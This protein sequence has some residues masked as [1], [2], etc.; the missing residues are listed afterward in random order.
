MTAMPAGLLDLQVLSKSSEPLQNTPMSAWLR[1][2]Q[3]SSPAMV[4]PLLSHGDKLAAITKK[5]VEAPRMV[6][7][8]SIPSQQEFSTGGQGEKM[9]RLEGLIQGL[10]AYV[11][12]KKKPAIQL[13][14]FSS[15]LTRAFL[16]LKRTTECF[17]A[18]SSQEVVV[19]ASTPS[20]KRNKRPAASP[21]E[22]TA[23]EKRTTGPH[24]HEHDVD[25]VKSRRGRR[26][27]ALQAEE[28][29]RGPRPPRPWQRRVRLR[30]DAIVVKAT[31][32][33][34]FADI[35]RRLYA[36]SVIQETVGRAVQSI[37]RSASGAMVLQLR[38]GV[39][40][41]SALGTE[42][43]G[44]LG[45]ATTASALSHK[46][47]LEIRD[48]DECATREEIR[49]A[50][51]QQL[52]AANLDPDAVRS[53]RKAY[54]G[55]QTAVID[56]PDELAAKAIK[57]GHLRVG[58][59]SCRVRERA[60]ASRC[61]RCWEFDHLA[62]RCVGPDRSKLCYQCGQDGHRAKTCGNAPCIRPSEAHHSRIF[63]SAVERGEGGPGQ[64]APHHSR[65]FQ[66]LVDG[67]GQ[68]RDETSRRHSPRRALCSR[69]RAAEHR[70]HAHLHRSSRQLPS[71]TPSPEP[72]ARRCPAEGAGTVA[73]INPSTGGQRRST[74]SA[75]SVCER[76]DSLIG[77]G[78]GPWR[79]LAS[80]I[81]PSRG[82]DCA[83][84]SRTASAA[85]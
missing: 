40:N 64:E 1:S 18:P 20:S 22:V 45:D 73:A 49:T 46:T 38:K 72:V 74:L 17:K 12:E 41:A 84:P 83:L 67:V 14:R 55:T 66:R 21:P 81:S 16:A 80:P 58:W 8:A 60:E 68:Q 82:A 30:P 62:T 78:E 52:G 29:E 23:M 65:R 39:Q 26:R 54:A 15:C 76:E 31:G 34:T 25:V 36:E 57:L 75:N 85:A 11:K 33:T 77:R 9:D 2:S 32:T 69:R 3:P 24:P 27:G 70:T 59:V 53:L 61:F 48:L 56:L 5:V 28:V 4:M 43:D 35:L 63:C 71:S 7:D 42:L 19:A 51:C 44:V 79:A 47:P 37:R 10:A 6:K 13:Q 50:L